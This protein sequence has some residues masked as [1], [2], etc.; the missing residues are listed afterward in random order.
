MD[1]LKH[2]KDAEKR[3][4]LQHC[5]LTHSVETVWRR[6]IWQEIVKKTNRIICVI[7][8]STCS[9]T[10]QTD[11][12]Y[13]ESLRNIEVILDEI[14]RDYASAPENLP[15][16]LPEASPRKEPYDRAIDMAI[17]LLKTYG[18][19]VGSSMMYC[20]AWEGRTEGKGGITVCKDG[21]K[22]LGGVFLSKGRDK[23]ILGRKGKTQCGKAEG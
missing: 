4:T 19:S 10:A 8:L 20:D 17:V 7:Q 16:P 12:T 1:S 3:A 11:K 21:Q 9:K 5:A 2:V 13:A 22:I 6:V 14:M 18:E 15:R 23:G